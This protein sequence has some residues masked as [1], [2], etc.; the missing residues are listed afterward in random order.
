MDITQFYQAFFEEADELLAEMEQ[1]LLGLDP[2]APDSEHLN[3]IFRV[4]HS[5]KG[6]AATF[7]FVALTDTTHL[8]ENL[9]DRARHGELQLTT[10]MIDAFLETKDVL[11]KQLSAYRDGGEPEPEMVARICAILRQLALESG[12]ADPALTAAP[13]PVP[14]AAP[15]AAPVPVAAPA[16]PA[17][18]GALK[19]HFS[20]VSENDRKLL[21]EELGNLGSVVAETQTDNSLTIWLETACD[22]DD[23]IAVCCFI[24][25]ADQIEI[26]AHP[27]APL[28]TAKEEVEVP[29]PQVTPVVPVAAAPDMPATA[30]AAA[31]TAAVAAAANGKE[32][33]S[34]RVDVEK[35]DQI[36][37][38]VGEL[39]ITQSML[40]QTA[41]TLDPVLHERLLSG[42]GHLERNARDLQESVMSIRMMPMDYVFSRFPRLIRDLSAKLGKQIQL[43]T[44]GK[45]TEL[46]KGLIE[47]IIDPITHLVRN[48]LDHGIEGPEQRAMAGKDPVGR[49]T[50]SAQ[51]QGGS[52]VIEVKDDGGG[53]VREKIIAKALQQGMAISETI[54]DEEVWQLIFAPG[55]STAETVTDVS[56]RGVGMDVVK[57]NIHEM[58]GHVEIASTQGRGTT[59]RI[60]LPLT[61]AILNGMSVKVGNEVYILPLNYVI[62]SL[63]PLA[64]DVHSITSDEH[65]MHVRGEYLAL[66]ELHKL[67][68][69]SGAVLNPMQGIAV[70]VQADG[71]RF[72]L[73]VDQL[74]GQH[75]VVVK[76]LETNYRKVPGISAATILGDGNVALIIDV[77]AVQRTNREKAGQ[78]AAAPA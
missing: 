20:K 46:D 30:T 21:S 61:L 47:R 7:G 14:A 58:G 56:G 36:I 9:L 8:A 6:G 65:V 33:S 3:A 10:K 68:D 19:V 2:Q 28:V 12:G 35:V 1:L 69:V 77:V 63:Q 42:M 67:F 74:V 76:N 31:A 52:I 73:L 24:V 26:S 38:L 27:A 15:V 16:T 18:G 78:L 32:S 64:K 75:Q 45:E 70:I 5:I 13:M 41:S 50:L 17:A 4:A 44:V 72:A 11:Q 23:L 55:F 66:I 39:V 22:A 71:A 59:I 57:R 54:S 34:I 25:E 37:N 40:T 49:L 62:E 29:A 43:V 51:H 53:L 60:V 48:S